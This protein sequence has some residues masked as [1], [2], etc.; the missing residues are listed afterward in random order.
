MYSLRGRAYCQKEMY[1]FLPTTTHS[2]SALVLDIYIYSVSI[3]APSEQSHL[4][5]LLWY[6]YIA[7]LA[8]HSFSL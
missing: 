3:T 7:L 4:Q 8:N 5:A 2:Q 6:E 1:I